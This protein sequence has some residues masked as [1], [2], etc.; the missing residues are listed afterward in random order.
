MHYLFLRYCAFQKKDYFG[1][2]LKKI[3]G[4]GVA[5]LWWMNLIVTH[6]HPR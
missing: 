3:L 6:T 5:V 4:E 2:F 1:A